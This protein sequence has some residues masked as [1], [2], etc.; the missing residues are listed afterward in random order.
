M[1]EIRHKAIIKGLDGS[2]SLYQKALEHLRYSQS[3]LLGYEYRREPD[4]PMA[5]LILHCLYRGRKSF[6]VNY[7][8]PRAL[9][10]NIAIE[11]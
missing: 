11:Y 1:V 8:I 4:R 9:S 3:I 5:Q 6:F 10:F 2:L 7:V